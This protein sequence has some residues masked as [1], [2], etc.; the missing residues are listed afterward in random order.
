[1]L[2]ATKG[3]AGRH[4]YSKLIKSATTV[5]KQM[6]YGAVFYVSLSF[7]AAAVIRT[8]NLST[9]LILEVRGLR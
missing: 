3:V 6:C 2:S 7:T 9:A 1:M 8:I 5:T 4:L